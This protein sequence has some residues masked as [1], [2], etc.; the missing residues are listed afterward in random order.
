[1]NVSNKE[2]GLKEGDKPLTFNGLHEVIS[3][4]IEHFMTT[5]VR[6]SNP[7]KYLKLFY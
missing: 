1:M 7:T 4:K 3:P 5:A 2:T 6:T